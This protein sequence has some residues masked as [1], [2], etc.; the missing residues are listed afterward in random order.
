MNVEGGSIGFGVE[1]ETDE[2]KLENNTRLHTIF[3][4]I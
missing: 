4:D 2:G 1:W 3:I